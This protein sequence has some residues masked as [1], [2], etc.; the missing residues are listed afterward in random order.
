MISVVV[1]IA[2]SDG[3]D[4]LQASSGGWERSA[5]LCPGFDDDCHPS[6]HFI[7]IMCR[8]M[9]RVHGCIRMS[10]WEVKRTTLRSESK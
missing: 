8:M 9:A 3:M 10:S 4:V 1:V 2:P 6:H 7:I 5:H